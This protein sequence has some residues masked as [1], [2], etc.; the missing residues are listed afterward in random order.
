[1]DIKA[2]GKWALGQLPGLATGA[3]GIIMLFLTGVLD[4]NDKIA[5][6][7]LEEY[8]AISQQQEEFNDL[9]SQI[10]A[11]LATG[12]TVDREKVALLSSNLVK[13]YTRIGAFSVNL[14]TGADPLVSDYRRTLNE[15]KTGI[16]RLDSLDDMEFLATNIAAM[17]DAQARLDPILQ[18]AAGKPNG[19]S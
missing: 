3:L 16:L 6:I 1:M 10:T 12:G 14:D 15:V 2:V 9:L 8:Q 4:W 17:Y 11:E 5:T 19:R 7:R 18:R 13:Q